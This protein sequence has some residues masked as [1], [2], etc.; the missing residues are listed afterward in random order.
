M[1]EKKLEFN[2]HSKHEKQ[3]ASK[4]YVLLYEMNIIKLSPTMIQNSKKHI[5][6]QHNDQ[7]LNTFVMN[8]TKI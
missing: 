1:I 6:G 3:M 2:F 8:Q 4:S 7:Q 5:F